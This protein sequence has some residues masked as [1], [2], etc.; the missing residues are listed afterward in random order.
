MTGEDRD[1]E[2]LAE[3]VRVLLA[4][5][6]QAGLAWELASEGDNAGLARAACGALR[7]LASRR[8]RL[9]LAKGEGLQGIKEAC[10]TVEA[11]DR[12]QGRS[13]AAFARA[14]APDAKGRRRV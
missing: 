3:R 12:S 11:W 6:R 10:E 7:V 5:P 8:C 14:D 1:A 2:R 4:M 13:A 9:L